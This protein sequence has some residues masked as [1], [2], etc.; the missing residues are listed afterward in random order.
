MRWVTAK[1]IFFFAVLIAVT[2]WAMRT[3]VPEKA[4]MAPLEYKF[5]DA[6]SPVQ[7]GLTWVG[8]KVSYWISFPVSM[9]GAAERNRALEEEMAQ[10][11]SQVIQLTEYKLENQRLSELLGY[12]QVMS[13]DYNLLAA[14]VVSRDSVS[15][16]GTVTLNRGSRD[17]VKEN[18]TVLNPEGL[19]GR[20]VTA[21]FTTCEVLL[22]TDPRSGVGCLI[23]ETRIPGI[24]EGTMG[25]SGMAK[26]IHIPNNIPVEKDQ[27][28]VTSGLGSIFPKGIPVGTIVSTKNESSG[29]FVSADIR[30]YADLS[31]LEEVLIVTSVN[32]AALTGP[33]GE[34]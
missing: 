34:S 26:M 17:G 32:P 27:V 8:K 29:L 23:Q 12:K 13:Q 9:V 18:M 1:R 10:L 20:V 24:V 22:L 31:K 4:R 19:V 30:L 11:K 25:S 7:S 3:T 16:F 28:V 2:L 6:L 21:S 5:R 15:W 33:G 14:S